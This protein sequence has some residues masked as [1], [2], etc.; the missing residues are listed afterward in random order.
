LESQCFI[1]GYE[2]GDFTTIHVGTDALIR[3]VERSSTWFF[4]ASRRR[5]QN[6]SEALLRRTDEGVRPYVVRG[7]NC[8]V[9]RRVDRGSASTR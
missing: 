3:P 7:G 8:G 9:S 2:Y 1:P 5:E 6:K 4:A